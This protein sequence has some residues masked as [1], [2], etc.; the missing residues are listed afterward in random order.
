MMPV[1][2]LCLLG[3]AALGTD[4]F[5]LVRQLGIA[6]VVASGLLMV[7]LVRQ[8]WQPRVAYRDGWAL[9]YLK[10]GAPFAVPV[11][12]V[13]AFFLGEGPAH[14]QGV[15]RSD[16]KTVNLI[17]RLSQRDPQWQHREIKAA[18]GKWAEGY[19]TIRG[20]WCEPLTTE[21]LRGLNHRLREVSQEQH[22]LGR[23][24]PAP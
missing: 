8:L 1:A 17:A 10:W 20:A 19:I 6:C 24:E 3:F 11:C 2:A 4:R 12:V 23:R 14:L 15:T 9:F 16:T 7:G 22:A 13:E 5:L 18:L 21:L